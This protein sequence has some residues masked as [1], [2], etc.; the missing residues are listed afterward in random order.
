V[1]PANRDPCAPARARPPLRIMVPLALAVA[2][3]LSALAS[4][5][6]RG[7]MHDWNS[8]THTARDMLVG[9][10]SYDPATLRNVLESYVTEADR[11]QR[12]VNTSTPAAREFQ[13]DFAKLQSDAKNSLAHL[14]QR[15]LL[16]GDFS[17]IVSDCNACHNRFRN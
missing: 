16:A 15:R 12:A 5:P 1:R 10:T 2:A 3:P 14:G 7:I 17:R 4:I 11:V 13:A 8:N 6:L 9:R